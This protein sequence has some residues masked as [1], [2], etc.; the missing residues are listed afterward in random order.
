MP[1]KI[2]IYTIAKN[3]AQFCERWVKS[4]A[5][6]DGLHVL[7]TGSTDGTVEILEDLGVHV[8][9]K[10][11]RS[12]KTIE[13]YYSILEEFNKG[14]SKEHPWRFDWPRNTNLQMVPKDADVCIQV[15]MDE[16]FVPNWREVVEK[17][18]VDGVNH[19]GY[20]YA[21]QM[22]SND[23]PVR[24]F[25]YSKCHA[26][27]GFHWERPVHEVIWPIKGT[28]EKMAYSNTLLVKHYPDGSKSRSSYL[29]L[30]M[31]AHK[32]NPKCSQSCFYLARE[33]SF[34]SMWVETIKQCQKYLDLGHLESR[35]ERA[36]ALLLGAKGYGVL[37][38]AFEQERWLLRA[39]AEC[40]D[41]REAWCDLADFYRVTNRHAGGLFA[42]RRAL[43]ITV[44]PMSHLVSVEAWR[45]RPYD[46][47]AVC[48]F[49]VGDK[50]EALK[51]AWMALKK[52]PMD[53]RLIDNVSF[54]K[55][56]IVKCDVSSAG[57]SEPA[58]VE[59]II[60][61]YS[62]D[63]EHYEMTRRC[64]E[65]LLRSSTGTS[66][67]IVVV[68]TNKGLMSESFFKED[69]FGCGSH[70]VYPECEF[71]YNRYLQ[72]GYGVIPERSSARC[73]MILNNDVV[74][75]SQDFVQKM[76]AATDFAPSVSP[77]GLREHTWNCVDESIP[78]Q[79]GYDINRQ[80]SGW[81]IMIDKAIFGKVS[82]EELF[83]EHILF[84]GQDVEYAK[85][86]E[87]NGIKHALA[88]EAQ[89][90]H[91]QSQ[92]HCLINGDKNKFLSK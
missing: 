62:K 87:I 42:A 50:E 21:W 78:I 74:E 43:E 85:I 77:L 19:M 10:K 45:E 68:E 8:N 55:K 20:Y 2:H 71:G 60:L 80:L 63:K 3:E 49:Y 70:I 16:V 12:W 86:L 44:D 64:V 25:F 1:L 53:G 67:R 9:Q 84:Y 4:C 39:A 51:M 82:F 72:Y 24:Q 30:L 33:Y 79:Y 58:F 14:K 17:H 52:N 54:I 92:S 76:I 31:L 36:T 37:K 5:D 35:M 29:N 69:G 15:D 26:R 90:L 73:V 38:N 88:C 40:P 66:L 61:S 46:N 6:T 11:Y 83:P 48:G 91:L 47:A 65:N 32:E 57:M 13:E 27:H 34:N 18:W 23:K 75:F 7:D 28:V 81:C 41:Q 59:V 56:A 22:D 89:A